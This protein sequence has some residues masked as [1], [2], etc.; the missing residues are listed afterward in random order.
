[1][2]VNLFYGH[3]FNSTNF[4]HKFVDCRSYGINDEVRNDY[5]APHNI[6]CYKFHNYGHIAQNCRLLIKPSVKENTNDR[7]KNAWRRSEKQE[8]K[9]NEEHVQGIIFIGFAVAQVHDEFIGKEGG[10]GI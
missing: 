3:C 1:M 2:Y 10:V 9:V 4:G 8:E 5:V 7:Y 6:E